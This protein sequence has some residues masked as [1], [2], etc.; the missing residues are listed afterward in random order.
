VTERRVVPYIGRMG[1]FASTLAVATSVVFAAGCAGSH[2][3]S[4]SLASGPKPAPIVG[5]GSSGS[6]RPLVVP[7]SAETTRRLKRLHSARFLS[8]TRLAIPGTLG[9]SN[10]PSVPV[11]L[12]V[13]S[14][15]AIRI[16][17][18]VG[19]WSRTASGLRVRVPHRPRICLTDL[20]LNSPLVIAINPKQIDV[21][22]QLKISLYYPRF[23]V[24]RYE[25]PV[26]V[27]APPL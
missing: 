10:C 6:T 1:T 25:H 27:A 20:V 24:R 4:A 26:V 9:S 5:A 3:K 19:S 22:H 11:K 16:D 15:H 18:A 12:V 2:A 14:P 23:V 17:L 13:F 8:P 21:H 7:I